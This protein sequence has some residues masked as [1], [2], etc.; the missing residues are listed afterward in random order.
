[1]DKRKAKFVRSHELSMGLVGV[2]E[3]LAQ[4]IEKMNMRLDQ[5][6]L[7]NEDLSIARSM[8]KQ[9]L[10]RFE[11]LAKMYDVCYGDYVKDKFNFKPVPADFANWFFD[12]LSIK[13]SLNPDIRFSAK[14]YLEYCALKK[15]ELD[16]IADT[17]NKREVQKLLTK[18]DKKEIIESHLKFM[19]GVNPSQ[20][21]IL[22]PNDYEWL[23]S[24]T[25]ELVEIGEC[26]TIEKA[27]RPKISAT[28]ISYTFYLIHK[29]IFTTRPIRDGFIDFLNRAFKQFANTEWTTIK[30]KFSV[31]HKG[32]PYQ[33]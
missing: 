29:E 10:A 12:G 16:S 13:V 22:T 20:E 15:K 1:M 31:K 24:K 4:E 5:P 7:S 2:S 27:I 32:F 11:Q 9:Q 21:S 8:V 3:G 33:Q 23:L 19:N 30:T 18:E 25:I 14:D 26:P 17:L 28:S 6:Y